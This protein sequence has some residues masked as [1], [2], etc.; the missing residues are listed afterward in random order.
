MRLA[1]AG[2][3]AAGVD[4]R[5]RFHASPKRKREESA[6]QCRVAPR[7]S[8]AR[9]AGLDEAGFPARLLFERTF[10]A[11]QVVVVLREAMSLVADVFQEPQ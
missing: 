1:W 7:I 9:A 5:P 2:G 6:I 4:E 10:L 8:L 11:E 3:C